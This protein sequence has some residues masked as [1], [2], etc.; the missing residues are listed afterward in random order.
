MPVQLRGVLPASK[1]MIA[2]V[3]IWPAGQ[4]FQ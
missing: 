1:W 4:R 3:A 2:A